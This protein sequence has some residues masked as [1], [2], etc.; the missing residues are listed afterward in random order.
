MELVTR[1]QKGQVS[2]R[3]HKSHVPRDQDTE[4]RSFSIFYGDEVQSIDII[5]PTAET[6]DKWY[7]GLMELVLKRVKPGGNKSLDVQ[8]IYS[9]IKKSW[10]SADKDHSDT[11][12][13]YEIVHWLDSINAN[14]P[15]L[16]IDEIF[17]KVDTDNS[18]VLDHDEFEKFY[19]LI[20]RRF[21]RVNIRM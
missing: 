9:D 5:A 14:I 3:F 13:K 10:A 1:I 2:N 4:N 21:I 12:S 15:K 8:E 17:R 16:L 18:G 11:L 19:A 20:H 7:F 6:F